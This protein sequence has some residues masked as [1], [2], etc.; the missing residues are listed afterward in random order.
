MK[1][2]ANSQIN[3]RRNAFVPRSTHYNFF[4][5]VLDFLINFLGV[6]RS[7]PLAVKSST[8]LEFYGTG[9]RLRVVPLRALLAARSTT[10][11]RN[12]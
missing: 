4:K 5:D 8:K 6:G 3:T 11:C 7:A 12:K 2:N 9:V 10:L 1:K